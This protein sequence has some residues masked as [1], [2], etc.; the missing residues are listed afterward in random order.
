MVPASPE[1]NLLRPIEASHVDSH[2]L[3]NET[4]LDQTIYDNK[5]LNSDAGQDMSSD[6]TIK[7]SRQKKLNTIE[8]QSIASD[9]PKQLSKRK[10]YRYYC[11]FVH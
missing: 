8:T 5:Q 6:D 7:S 1:Q 3:K 11:C 4:T 2:S 9:V 10:K